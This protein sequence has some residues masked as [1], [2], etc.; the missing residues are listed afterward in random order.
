MVWYGI[1]MVLV[2]C[3]YGDVGMVMIDGIIC[4]GT[5]SHC[6]AQAGLEPTKA[7]SCPSPESCLSL[8]SI[9]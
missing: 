6:V 9:R 4:F 7:L 3:W 8:P 2:G 1:G 5:E